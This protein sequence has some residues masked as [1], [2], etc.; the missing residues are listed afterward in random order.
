MWAAQGSATTSTLPSCAMNGNQTGRSSNTGVILPQGH[1]S[2]GKREE[3]GWAV[4]V[5]HIATPTQPRHRWLGT[6]GFQLG[7]V[8]LSLLMC[9]DVLGEK[10]TSVRNVSLMVTVVVCVLVFVCFLTLRGKK[11]AKIF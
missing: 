7:L 6:N 4:G 5:S 1:I 10:K 2:R 3:V 8:L 9:P 11:R